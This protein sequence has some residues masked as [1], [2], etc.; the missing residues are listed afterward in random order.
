MFHPFRP[1][2]I[3]VATRKDWLSKNERDQSVCTAIDVGTKDATDLG[4]YVLV[5][6]TKAY[7]YF[8]Q[9]SC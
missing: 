3:I 8:H 4:M 7:V 6:L 5:R 9:T 2:I 1:E